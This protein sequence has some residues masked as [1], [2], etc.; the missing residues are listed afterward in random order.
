MRLKSFLFFFV[1]VLIAGLF[2][3]TCTPTPNNPYDISNT[4]IYLV[5]RTTSQLSENQGFADS[6]GN[7][8][9]AGFSCNFPDNI[10]SVQLKLALGNGKDSIFKS[11]TDFS[12]VKYSDTLW[13][14]IVFGDS[15]IKTIKGVAYIKNYGIPYS[16][17]IFIHIF[18]KLPNHAPVL[19]LVSG[20]T[21][22]VPKQICLLTLAANDPDPA[23]KDSITLLQGPFSKLNDSM[24][25]WTPDSNSLGIDSAIFMAWDNGYPIMRETLRLAIT[26]VG[27]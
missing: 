4:K 11:Y 20:Q 2:Y 23:Q 27:T 26:V 24:F 1:S 16:V 10:D 5:A 3:L 17:S 6:I 7:P 21:T 18:G 15:G 19:S 13:Q 22:I 25:T 8:I 12:A 14:T 9:S